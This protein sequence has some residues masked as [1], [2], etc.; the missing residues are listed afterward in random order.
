[1]MFEILHGLFD[2]S[3]DKYLIPASLKTRSRH[4]QTRQFQVSSDYYMNSFFPK[5]I[6]HSNSLL[7]IVVD[8]PS[9]VSFKR[10][11][12]VLIF[13]S[14]LPVGSKSSQVILYY[15]SG[16]FGR[17]GI[18]RVA[19]LYRREELNMHPNKLSSFSGVL[20]SCSVCLIVPFFFFFLSRTTSRCK[21]QG[22]RTVRITYMKMMM[23]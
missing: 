19:K 20:F 4:E 18:A 13:Y 10:E 9:L 17:R 14:M 12:S 7:A 8:S 3:P 2:M 22:W 16:D 5:T 15:A 21:C 11:L 23:S 1:M 6:C